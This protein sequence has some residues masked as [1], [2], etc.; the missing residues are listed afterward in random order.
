MD[1][2]KKIKN[3]LVAQGKFAKKIAEKII[4]KIVIALQ[5]FVLNYFY[6]T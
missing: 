6:V 5:G 3:W 4:K 2:W 1:T